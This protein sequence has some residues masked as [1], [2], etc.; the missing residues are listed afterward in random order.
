MIIGINFQAPVKNAKWEGTLDATKDSPVCYQR[1]PYT[2]S[3]VIEGDE[4][5]LYLNVY[6]PSTSANLPVMVFF[7]GGGWV[8]GAGTSMWYGPDILLDRDVVL[9]V[10]NFRLGPLGFLST[11]DDAA[12]GNAGLKDQVMAL[13]WVRENI[14]KFGG[15]PQRVTAF[16]ESAGGASVHFHM[17]SPLSKGLI[18]RG[19]SQS[20]TALCSWAFSQ[21]GETQRNSK[22]LAQSF[23]CPTQDSEMMVECLREITAHDIIDKDRIFWVS[24]RSFYY[25]FQQVFRLL[26]F[27]FQ[28]ITFF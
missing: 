2:R 10:P 28:L 8:C 19:I 9:V 1:N 12:P 21:S 7:H 26:R 16:G 6:T 11:G 24:Q 15:D 14:A 5:C 23:G 20:G 18:H 25:I 27:T 17:M 3:Q 22:K 4:N 13:E